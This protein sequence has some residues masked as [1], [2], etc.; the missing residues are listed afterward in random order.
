MGLVAQQQQAT[1][2]PEAV[3]VHFLGPQVSPLTPP[4]GALQCGPPGALYC[5]RSL[6][7][8]PCDPAPLSEHAPPQFPQD[9]NFP[10]SLTPVIPVLHWERSA[11]TKGGGGAK[12]EGAVA[13]VCPSVSL[14]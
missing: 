10:W 3:G 2:G 13:S 14:W 9:L 6:G 1:V 12:P 4:W 11:E 7:R 5:A 8:G